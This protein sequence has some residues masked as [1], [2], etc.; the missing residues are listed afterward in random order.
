MG[1]VAI[2]ATCT[3]GTGGLCALGAP[4]IVAGSVSLGTTVGA[5]A[6]A[7]AQNAG[8]ITATL[9]SG[10]SNWGRRFMAAFAGLVVSTNTANQALGPR[11]DNG[12]HNQPSAEQHSPAVPNIPQPE[13]PKPMQTDSGPERK[14]STEKNGCNK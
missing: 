2:A 14:D 5:A 13:L 8:A 12:P 3:A 9:E 7:V 6:D 4:A 10:A 11:C 1:G